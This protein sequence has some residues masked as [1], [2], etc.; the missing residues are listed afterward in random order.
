M[1]ASHTFKSSEREKLEIV[2]GLLQQSGYS[3]SRISLQSDSYRVKAVREGV[4]I[5]EEEDERL[6]I[7][8]LVDHF[9]IE[10]WSST[11]G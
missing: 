4:P 1:K 9:D 11:V 2:S 5:N 10:E 6:R 8:S 3:A 7:Q